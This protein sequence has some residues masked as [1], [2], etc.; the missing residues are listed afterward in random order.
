MTDDEG[1]DAMANAHPCRTCGA[2]H[3]MSAWLALPLAGYSGRRLDAGAWQATEMR[4]CRCGS[5]L[6]RRVT[7]DAG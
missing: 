1:C 2:W 3:V 4:T 5:T 7:W 6:A